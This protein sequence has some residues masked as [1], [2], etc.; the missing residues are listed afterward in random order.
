M[1]FPTGV[2][3]VCR[4]LLGGDRRVFLRMASTSLHR[5]ANRLPTYDPRRCA[6]KSDRE[7]SIR[8][9]PL[10]CSHNTRLRG[11]ARDSRDESAIERSSIDVL[12]RENGSLR[13]CSSRILAENK[14]TGATAALVYGD[15]KFGGT[16]WCAPANGITEESQRCQERCSLGSRMGCCASPSVSRVRTVHADVTIEP[17]AKH[18]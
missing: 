17:Q 4:Y 5:R 7:R 3:R 15:T 8:T 9:A 14:K 13:S 11:W 16:V 18:L 12:R 2:F 1:H 10:P 6:D